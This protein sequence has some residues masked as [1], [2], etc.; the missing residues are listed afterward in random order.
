VYP[1]QEYSEELAARHWNRRRGDNTVTHSFFN[2]LARDIFGKALIM[3][4][5]FTRE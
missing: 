1:L 2:K 3:E 5:P 4:N